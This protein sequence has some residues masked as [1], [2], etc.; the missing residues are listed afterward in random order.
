[1]V[2]VAS[3]H[4]QIKAR[5]FSEVRTYGGWV[6]VADWTPYGRKGEQTL[7]ATPAFQGATLYERRGPTCYACD[8]CDGPRHADE[9][10]AV[11]ELR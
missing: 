6:K 8:V 10:T 11:W 7:G 5:G 9:V 1:M 2:T 3:L 4:E